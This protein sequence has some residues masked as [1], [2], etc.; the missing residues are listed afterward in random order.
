MDSGLSPLMEDTMA[1]AQGFQREF[2]RSQAGRL[3][4]SDRRWLATLVDAMERTARPEVRQVP[5][6]ARLVSAAAAHLARPVGSFAQYGSAFSLR[7]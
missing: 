2:H 1:M 4:G 7:N 6:D 5:C 3:G